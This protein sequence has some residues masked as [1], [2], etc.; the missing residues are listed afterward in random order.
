MT[1]SILVAY[2]TK[3]GSTE[4]VAE[5]VATTLRESGLEVDVRPMRRVDSLEEYRAVVLGAPIYIGRWHGDARQFLT[6][7]QDALM[8]RPVA[9]FALGPLKDTDEE[10]AG[11]REQ[12]DQELAKEAWLAPIAVEMFGG[13]YDPAKLSLAHRLMGALPA[14]PLHGRPASDIRDWDAIRAWAAAVAGQLQPALR[15]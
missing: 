2:A 8:E 13:V 11:S 4:E 9:V 6:R 12:L 1:A 7:H 3:Y 15:T 14:S 10:V 5:A